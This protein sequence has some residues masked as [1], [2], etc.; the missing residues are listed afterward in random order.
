M[1][2]GFDMDGVIADFNSGMH[3]LMVGMTERDLFPPS[4]HKEG[5]RTWNFPLDYGYT[6]EEI[7]AA[8]EVIK[9][10][11]MFWMSLDPHH[12]A[13]STLKLVWGLLEKNH[14]VY[15]ITNRMGVAAK[16]QSE[17]WLLQHLIL[18]TTGKNYMHRAGYPP[19]H[20]TVLLSGE[21]GLCALALQ[22]DAYVD[23][24]FENIEDVTFHSPKTRAYLLHKPYNEGR[25]SRGVRIKTLGE[26]LDA[27]IRNL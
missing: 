16:R 2:V 14:E 1:R 21:K 9:A 6:P 8:W 7:N 4:F 12:D 17:I 24:R 10:D 13:L 5:P 18:P 27:E 26:M 22:L 19:H 11:P 25:V 3:E 20:P 23:D 15:F